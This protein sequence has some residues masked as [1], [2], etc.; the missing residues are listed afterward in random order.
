MHF[1]TAKLYGKKNLSTHAPDPPISLPSKP[2][3]GSPV[4]HLCSAM[5]WFLKNLGNSRIKRRMSEG[6]A[7][8]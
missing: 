7:A 8:R 2:R 4:C 1:L 6:L 3:R 5:A